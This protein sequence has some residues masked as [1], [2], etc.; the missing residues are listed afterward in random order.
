MRDGLLLKTK[1]SAK[2]TTV[3][4][5]TRIFFAG[6]TNITFTNTFL[7]PCMYQLSVRSK[8]LGSDLAYRA[9]Y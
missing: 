3:L 6:I 9:E 4:A 5:H 8:A 7:S 1:I 2:H